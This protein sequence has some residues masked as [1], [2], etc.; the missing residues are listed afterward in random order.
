MPLGPAGLP[1]ASN[2]LILFSDFPPTPLART[3]KI[4]DAAQGREQRQGADMRAVWV[5]ILGAVLAV[6][7]TTASSN[8]GAIKKSA[9]DPAK[10]KAFASA[11]RIIREHGLVDKD[12]IP[13]IMVMLE[14][15]DVR[16]IAKLVVREN[17]KPKPPQC[18]ADPDTAPAMFWLEIDMQTGKAKW[19]KLDAEDDS[20]NMRPVPRYYI[21]PIRFDFEDGRT[22]ADLSR[23]SYTGDLDKWLA[24]NRKHKFQIKG[25]TGG[26]D[27]A[28]ARARA[29][30]G[31]GAACQARRAQEPYGGAGSER[32]VPFGCRGHDLRL[33]ASTS[34]S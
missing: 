13:C 34:S 22:D 5:G 27:A 29:G 1:R 6:A 7:S 19:N 14:D 20:G 18:D 33:A 9:S 30:G 17:H 12:F 4:S 24:E 23:L 10:E 32:A 2:F 28:L 31:T 3:A 15:N 21:S 26:K 8:T 25:F 16:K 11:S